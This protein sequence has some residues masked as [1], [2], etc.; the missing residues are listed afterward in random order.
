M[1]YQVCQTPLSHFYPKTSNFFILFLEIFIQ[2][3]SFFCFGQ[4]S[5]LPRPLAKCVLGLYFT[6]FLHDSS[7]YYIPCLPLS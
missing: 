7:I 4:D 3:S 5:L 1:S 2:I 6:I